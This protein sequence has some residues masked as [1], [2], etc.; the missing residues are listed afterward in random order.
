MYK[1]INYFDVNL[2]LGKQ[3]WR[4]KLILIKVLMK[5][6]KGRMDNTVIFYVRG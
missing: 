2:E 1:F 5:V 3:L 4:Y 6:I